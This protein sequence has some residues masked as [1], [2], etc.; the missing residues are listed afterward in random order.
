MYKN[1]LLNIII[2]LNRKNIFFSFFCVINDILLKK[3]LQTLFRNV[4]HFLLQSEA[5][6][7]VFIEL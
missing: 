2:L 1:I 4:F 3:N 6:S 5:I 7:N